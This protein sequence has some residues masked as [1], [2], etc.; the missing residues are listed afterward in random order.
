MSSTANTLQRSP[1]RAVV[2]YSAGHVGSATILNRLLDAPEFEV[3]GIVKSQSVPFS[4]KGLKRLRRHLRK[5]GWR[6]GWLMFWQQLMQAVGFL[7]GGLLPSKRRLKPAWKLARDRNIPLFDC[8]NVNHDDTLRFIKSFDPELLVSAY[9]N[10]ILKPK[11]IR[12]PRVGVLNVHPGWLPAYRGAM[13]YFWVLKNGEEQGGVTVHWIDE[14]I[15][16]GP[17]LARR[18]FRLTAGMTQ[19]RVLLL[20]AV[21]GAGLL[22]RIARRLNNGETPKPLEQD[23]LP[24]ARYYPLPGSADFDTYFTHRRFFRLRDVFGYLLKK[25]PRRRNPNRRPV[26]R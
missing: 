13:V 2:L 19:Q 11:A 16:T 26:V 3:V 9:F 21:I 6:F 1:L 12:I 20:T 17:I 25:I 24:E 15:D 23:Q 10:Q 8:D 7:L 22:K 5:V 18:T 14:G 4:R